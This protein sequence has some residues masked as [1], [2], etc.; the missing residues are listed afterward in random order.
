MLVASLQSTKLHG[1]QIDTNFEP[2]ATSVEPGFGLLLTY[3]L[4][5]CE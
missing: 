1:I 5:Y 3:L 4:T 2:M